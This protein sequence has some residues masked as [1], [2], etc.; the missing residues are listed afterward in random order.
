MMTLL[1]LALLICIAAVIIDGVKDTEI[2]SLAVLLTVIIAC[3]YEYTDLFAL[4][5]LLPLRYF[6]YTAIHRN[7]AR[8]LD[9][10]HIV[11]HYIPVAMYLARRGCLRVCSTTG[12][13]YI[14]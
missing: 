1:L 4:V 6:I 14:V 7:I 10:K 3:I 2:S 9:K 13:N 12:Y 5:L 8:H 11:A